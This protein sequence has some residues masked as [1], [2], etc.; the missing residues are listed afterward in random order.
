MSTLQT[1]FVQTSPTLERYYSVG[2]VAEMWQLSET[3]VRKMFR[4]EPG[5]LQSQAPTLRPRKYPYVTL[6]IPESVLI[7]VRSRWVAAATLEPGI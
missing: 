3:K 1:S 5:V 6:R 4:D 7:R 2:E